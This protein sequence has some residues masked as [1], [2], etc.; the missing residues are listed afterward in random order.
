MFE[1]KFWLWNKL[2]QHLIFPGLFLSL[3]LCQN[4]KI[5]KRRPHIGNWIK[6]KKDTEY[7]LQFLIIVI[8]IKMQIIDNTTFLLNISLLVP[9]LSCLC[10]FLIYYYFFLKRLR[11]LEKLEKLE[12]IRFSEEMKG[13]EIKRK[14]RKYFHNDPKLIV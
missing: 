6:E 4:R 11:H 12:R 7:T 14:E 10:F 8:T 13:N 5:K 2:F 3:P 9:H 1:M